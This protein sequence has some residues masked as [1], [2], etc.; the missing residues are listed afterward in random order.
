LLGCYRED[1]LRLLPL[2]SLT[3]AILCGNDLIALTMQALLQEHGVRVPKECSV[4]GFDDMQAALA[5]PAMTTVSHVLFE[6]GLQAVA[7][8]LKRIAQRGNH[9]IHAA[10]ASRLVIRNS[11]GPAPGAALPMPIPV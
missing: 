7:V 1:L 3:T 5:F 9:N 11:T 2:P 6:L 10:V 4:I 8:A